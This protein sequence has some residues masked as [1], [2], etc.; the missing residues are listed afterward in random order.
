MKTEDLKKELINKIQN[1]SDDLLLKD[2]LK[3]FDLNKATH[4]YQLS[5]EEENALNIAKEQVNLGNS[6]TQAEVDEKMKKWRGK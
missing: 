1:T 4:F 5:I 2:V 3:F 6:Y